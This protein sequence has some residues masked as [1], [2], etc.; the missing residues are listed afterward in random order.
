MKTFVTS[1]LFSCSLLSLSAYGMQRD[2]ETKGALSPTVRFQEEFAESDCA[3]SYTWEATSSQQ[4]HTSEN[5]GSSIVHEDIRAW[6][7]KRKRDQERRQFDQALA[8]YR[9]QAEQIVVDYQRDGAFAVKKQFAAAVVGGIERLEWFGDDMDA[10]E[11]Q[12]V[13]DSW[14]TWRPRQNDYPKMVDAFV[15]I[16]M[17]FSDDLPLHMIV[18]GIRPD[19]LIPVAK[20]LP[21]ESIGFVAD[22]FDTLYPEDLNLCLEGQWTGYP[23]QE[24]KMEDLQDEESLRYWRQNSK[25][26]LLESICKDKFEVSATPAEIQVLY[27][28]LIDC[29]GSILAEVRK[30]PAQWIITFY[31]GLSKE[32]SVK[33]AHK[34]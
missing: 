31:N 22:I 25:T 15:A 14:D 27:E 17:L 30:N 13:I 23:F 19:N 18:G 1:L 5:E 34:I 7:N 16:K 9:A 20:K 29:D 28:Y 4:R 6:A 24:L 33:S 21:Q 10:I 32:P 8:D 3:A 26:H 2:E 11:Y 12:A